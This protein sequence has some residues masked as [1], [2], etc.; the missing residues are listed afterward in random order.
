MRVPALVLCL[1]LIAGC[2]KREEE[3]PQE[4]AKPTETTETEAPAPE[5][6][7]LPPAQMTP[8]FRRAAEFFEQAGERMNDG[9]YADAERL[10]QQA[11]AL[12][13]TEP[14]YHARHGHALSRLNRYEEAF[15]AFRQALEGA[16]VSR[17]Q[18]LNEL[19]AGQAFRVAGR[20][21]RVGDMERARKFGE[22]A[23][24]HNPALHHAWMLMGHLHWS[25]GHNTEAAA[26]FE[27]A[28]QLRTGALRD[29]AVF[30]KGQAL[31]AGLDFE[32]A[33]AAYNQVITNGYREHD[34]YGWRGQVLAALGRND[35]AIRDF[36]RAIEFATSSAARAEFEQDLKTLIEQEQE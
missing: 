36:H 22:Y 34:V 33:L 24:E 15:R 35:E 4:S 11:L 3:P 8:E 14:E 6:V 16:P 27:K 1:L 7:D 26:A 2:V 29:E 25:E 23:I 9:R 13:P 19:A 31:H 18:E 32:G 30:R 17:R 10:M 20:A 12:N 28:S 21:H 5:P